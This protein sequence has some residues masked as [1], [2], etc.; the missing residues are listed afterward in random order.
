ME[1][2]DHHPPVA[3]SL[4]KKEEVE[5]PTPLGEERKRGRRRVYVSFGV[6]PALL[7]PPRWWEGSSSS[8][9]KKKEGGVR[10]TIEEQA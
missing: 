2:R 1:Q 4:P 7:P 5:V 3:S 9:K 8:T 10:E 6:L